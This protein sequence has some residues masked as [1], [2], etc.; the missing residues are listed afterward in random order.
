MVSSMA[1]SIV[2]VASHGSCHKGKQN[3]EGVHL[4]CVE[5]I[6]EKLMTRT[7]VFPNIYTPTLLGRRL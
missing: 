4:V 5:R 1:I 2:L 7:A 3:Y 6:C